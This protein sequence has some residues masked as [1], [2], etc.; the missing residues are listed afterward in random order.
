MSL[1]P[2]NLKMTRRTFLAAG[3]LFAVPAFADPMK[4]VP[5][6]SSNLRSV[7]FD[8]MTK[9]LEVEF[10]HGGVYRYLEVPDDVHAELMK[11]ESKGRFFQVNVRG[12]FKFER[13]TARK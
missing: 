12:K 5:V 6:E 7:G 8:T 4:R 2:S 9:T 3:I 1:L 10:R 13:T 11:A